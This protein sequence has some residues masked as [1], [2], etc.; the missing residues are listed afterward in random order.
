VIEA[1]DKEVVLGLVHH[2]QTTN[3]EVGLLVQTHK[4]EVE[5]DETNKTNKTNNVKGNRKEETEKGT[6]MEYIGT[7]IVQNVNHIDDVK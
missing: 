6:R 1:E 4:V 3:K 7:K 2:V 5:D